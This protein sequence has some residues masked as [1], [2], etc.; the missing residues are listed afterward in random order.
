MAK[1]PPLDLTPEMGIPKVRTFENDH[2]EN[3]GLHQLYVNWARED[4]SIARDMCRQLWDQ[5]RWS[6]SLIASAAWAQVQKLIETDA[7]WFEAAALEF[8][9]AEATPL[10]DRRIHVGSSLFGLEPGTY[11]VY[12]TEQN[13]KVVVELDEMRTEKAE[14]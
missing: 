9:S 3:P 1:K 14:A 5:S 7:A 6:A 13:G 8:A 2:R 12:L 11:P 10:L 4:I